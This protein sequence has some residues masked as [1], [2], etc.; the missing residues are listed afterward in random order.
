MLHSKSHLTQFPKLRVMGQPI[1]RIRQALAGST[2]VELSADGSKVRPVLPKQPAVIIIR[3]APAGATVENIR[4][5]FSVEGAKEPE[6]IKEEMKGTFFVTMHSDED[7]QA[8]TQAW[9]AAKP[10]VLGEPLHYRLKAKNHLRALLGGAQPAATSGGLAGAAVHAKPFVPTAGGIPTFRPRV[11]ARAF[12]PPGGAGAGAGGFG[13]GGGGDF[14]AM[15]G[16]PQGGM[17]FGGGSGSGGG[18]GFGA[19]GGM[20]FGF[21]GMGGMGVTGGLRAAT[22]TTDGAIALTGQQQLTSGAPANIPAFANLPGFA[23]NPA[24]AAAAVAAAAAAAAGA[25]RASAPKPAYTVDELMAVFRR[26]DK[27][28]LSLP[29]EMRGDKDAAV[30]RKTPD[31]GLLVRQR[32]A[33]MDQVVQKG[34]PRIA[35]VASVDSVDYNNVMYGEER[36]RRGSSMAQDLAR[37][38]REPQAPPGQV[39]ATLAGSAASSATAGAGGMPN[40]F[41]MTPPPGAMMV[42]GG[43]S[44]G[45]GSGK[46]RKGGRKGNAA[47]GKG[48]PAQGQGKR[49]GAAGGNKG[50]KGAHNRAPQA[51]AAF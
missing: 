27:S 39:A 9:E 44:G 46:S 37:A 22:G 36:K 50:G 3:D 5:V 34:R 4:E 32:S 40:F 31:M 24:L 1:D 7:A 12:V 48:S 45:W 33:S 17:G 23:G 26:I 49:K 10:V 2:T 13:F 29:H 6:S 15:G 18:M 43:G 35:S 28:E 42:G 21:P 47:G 14:S 51:P 19:P 25:Q 16:A 41:G 30:V 8:T 38:A 11:D 20:G